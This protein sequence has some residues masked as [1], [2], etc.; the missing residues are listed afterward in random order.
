[1]L[2][3]MK[4]LIARLEAAEGPDRELDV[5]IW[6]ALFDKQ[7]MVDGGGYGPKATEPKYKSAR[8]LWTD[9]WPHWA[10]KHDVDA[11]ALS[12]DAPKYTASIGAALALKPSWANCHGYDAIPGKCSAYF[13]LNHVP[14]GHKIVEGHAATPALALCIAA[15][16]AR[17]VG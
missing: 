4:D 15:L 10:N 1:M 17:D 16:K 2:A 5:R 12:L 11:V 9:H 13:S 6:L 3:D 8:E 7:I 14:T